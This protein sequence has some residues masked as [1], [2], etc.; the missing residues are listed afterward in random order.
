MDV[1]GHST[2]AVKALPGLFGFPS[3]PTLG[4]VNFASDTVIGRLQEILLEID[5]V[6]PSPFFNMGGDEVNF[7]AV[8]SLPEVVAAVHANGYTNAM[9]VYRAFIEKMR[10]FASAHNKTLHVWEGFGPEGGESGHKQANASVVPI[11]T[12]HL[13]VTIFDG[14]Y[15]NPL[16]IAADGYRIINSATAPLYINTDWSQAELIY[17]WHPWLFGDLAYAGYESWWELPEA[18]RGAVEGVQI[19]GWG[20]SPP[21]MLAGMRSKAP[22]MADRSWAPMAMRS[23]AD[24]QSRLAVA[25]SMLGLLLGTLPTPPTP[26]TP[27]P[28]PPPPSPPPVPGGAFTPQHGACRDANGNYGP[29]VE[30]HAIKYSACKAKC[31][32]FGPRCDAMYGARFCVIRFAQGCHRI[33]HL[34]ARECH[35]FPHLLSRMPSDPTLALS[36]MPSDPTPARVEFSR[37]LLTMCKVKNSMPC[38][39]SLRRE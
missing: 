37:S 27:P 32:S 35:R 22:A 10:V 31:D 4:I 25:D 7:A 9:D 21:A 8:C 29:R 5:A 39:F 36:R 26:P 23:Y 13:T 17:Q 14:V 19:C 2:A 1:P 3:A 38:S 24:F 20:M 33:P 15:Y 6:L 30:A 34:L 12:E 11:P 16:K 18:S 28:A